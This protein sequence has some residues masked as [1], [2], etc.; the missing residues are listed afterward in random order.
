MIKC[1]LFDLDGT[2]ID[3]EIYTI[4][5]KIIEGKKLG[6]DIKEEDVIG[7]FGLSKENSRR[8]FKSIYGEDFPYDELSL[9]RFQY[10]V[11]AMKE[12]NLK[13]MPYAEDIIYSLKEEGI[14]IC[15]CTSTNLKHL[16]VYFSLFPLLKEFD[17]YVTNDMVKNG[18]PS[19]DIFLEGMKKCGFNHLESLIVEDAISGVIAGM[20]SKAQTVMVPGFMKPTKEILESNVLIMKDLKEVKDY[21]FKVNNIVK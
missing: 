1:V 5:S 8:F 16:E 17:Y 13:A 3:S 15:L 12:G 19:P 2:I 11:K 20:N 21:I 18:K 7:S 14:K 9:F 10:I 4:S 6:Y